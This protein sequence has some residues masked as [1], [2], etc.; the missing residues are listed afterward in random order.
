MQ[1][2]FLPAPL[3]R[4]ALRLAHRLRHR[5]RRWRRVPLAGVSLV[6]NDGAGRVLLVRHSYGPDL[7]A[8]PGGGIAAGEDP[9]QAARREA[10]EE[11]GCEIADLRELDVVDD[12][13][14]G[15]PHRAHIFAGR[16]TGAPVPDRREV[17]EGRF[18]APD[19][20]PEQL[21]RLVRPRLALWLG[22]EQA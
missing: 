5:W 19:A 8:L 6:L 1:P 11:L 12:E 17:V 22:S 20:L 10:L 13:I 21:G 2:T 18:F 16:L 15:S 4:A 3:H 14:S 7:W 9:L